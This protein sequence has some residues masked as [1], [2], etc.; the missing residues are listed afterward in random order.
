MSIANRHP[1][2][3]NIIFDEP[4]IN[5]VWTL[6]YFLPSGF[7]LKYKEPNI[8]KHIFK[9]VK[10]KLGLKSIYVYTYQFNGNKEWFGDLISEYDINLV[11]IPIPTSIKSIGLSIIK[12]FMDGH[13]NVIFLQHHHGFFGNDDT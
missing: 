10:Q 3:Q 2:I 5:P 9:S 1:L 4:T 12:K 8:E 11:E 6:I 7:Y 13:S